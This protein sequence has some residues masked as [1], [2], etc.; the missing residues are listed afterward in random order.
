MR[1]LIITSVALIAALA[2]VAATAVISH[3]APPRAHATIPRP[4]LAQGG[5]GAATRFHVTH[6][7]RGVI[8][9]SST[10]GGVSH[11]PQGVS[12][13]AFPSPAACHTITGSVNGPFTGLTAA[14]INASPA[15][16][17]NARNCNFGVYVGP[18]HS[19]SISGKTIENAGLALANHSVPI[20]NVLTYGGTVTIT[21]SVLYDSYGDGSVTLDSPA[22]SASTTLTGSN[23]NFSGFTYGVGVFAEADWGNNASATLTNSTSFNNLFAQVEVNDNVGVASATINGG[24][25]TGGFFSASSSD[26]VEDIFGLA[27]ITGARLTGNED[28]GVFNL[29]GGVT[30]NNSVITGN[31]QKG[32]LSPHAGLYNVGFLTV[33]HSALGSDRPSAFA[34]AAF[35][36]VDATFN[37]TTTNSDFIGVEN[38][39]GFAQ[40]TAAVAISDTAGLANH[41]GGFMQ[42]NG[43]LLTGDTY[44]L[45]N[46]DFAASTYDFST[47]SIQGSSVQTVAGTLALHDVIG[48][49]NYAYFTGNFV[50]SNHNSFDGFYQNV[51]S[52]GTPS[53]TFFASGLHFNTNCDLQVNPLTSLSLVGTTYG[54]LCP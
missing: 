21:S 16:S 47:V 6:G 53:A 39:G 9:P 40:V 38:D 45:Y 23:V 15:T 28:A 33:S 35:T 3:A 49:V 37:F 27:T 7:K 24:T 43:A 20:A 8:I 10:G 34:D 29:F 32:T 51:V 1:K 30:I 44:G 11:K 54:S 52:S 48:I 2:A 41:N 42:I 14:V 26:G 18:G 5:A 4:S 50:Q 36:D 12:P 13:S 19:A 22:D 17:I 46:G 25:Y 31:V